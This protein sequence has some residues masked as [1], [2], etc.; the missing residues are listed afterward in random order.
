MAVTL[1]DAAQMA[2]DLFYQDYA[3]RDAFFSLPQFKFMFATTYSD[4]LDKEFQAMRV[5]GKQETGFANIEISSGWL[6]EEI[7][8]TVY[9]EDKQKVIAFTSQKVFAFRWDATGNALQGLRPVKGWD[10]EYRKI[11]LNELRF[12]HTLPTTGFTYYYLNNG[13]EIEFVYGKPNTELI[14]KYVPVVT[15]DNDNCLLA[16]GIV[17]PVIKETL[18]IMFG[19]KKETIIQTADDGNK[20][21]IMPQ[22]VNP[23][24]KS[25]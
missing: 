22:Q 21:T 14:V 25:A 3:P 12:I 13:R 5:A 8:T 17:M 24:L 20:N 7:I 6:I 4:M 9:N 18:N 11:S 10:N 16:D 2:M 15:Y 19:A 23:A 1:K